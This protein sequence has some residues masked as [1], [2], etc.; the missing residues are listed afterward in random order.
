[1]NSLKFGHIFRAT[2]IS[3]LILSIAIFVHE[4]I[5]WKGIEIMPS[6]L[7]SIYYTVPV[8]LI[9][10]TFWFACNFLLRRYILI[11]QRFIALQIL[12]CLLSTFLL[13]I[14]W[15]WINGI[16]NDFWGDNSFLFFFDELRRYWITAIYFGLSIPLILNFIVK[17]YFSSKEKV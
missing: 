5:I 16:Q 12:I 8:C 6:I 13:L 9:G 10:L 7:V 2:L 17:R 11:L 4:S 1:M 14:S 3:L 15:I